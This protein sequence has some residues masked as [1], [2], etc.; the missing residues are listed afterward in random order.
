MEYGVVYCSPLWG[1]IR[2][3]WSSSWEGT[4]TVLLLPSYRYQYQHRRR[5]CTTLHAV[6]RTTTLWVGR[7]V[8]ISGVLLRCG[9][10]E[11]ND[12]MEEDGMATMCEC[13]HGCDASCGLV[14]N[15]SASSECGAKYRPGAP[16]DCVLLPN[17]DNNH[18]PA[19]TVSLVL[20]N[21]AVCLR[22]GHRCDHG[23]DR[24]GAQSRRTGLWLSCHHCNVVD[25]T[26]KR[27]PVPHGRLRPQRSAAVMYQCGG[28]AP[29]PTV[30]VSAEFRCLPVLDHL[31]MFNHCGKYGAGL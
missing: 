15:R 18:R 27:V 6:V 13:G 20:A 17:R 26:T 28:D 4:P 5:K 3:V 23:L 16:T 14:V 25:V 19:T 31:P 9:R 12:G 24:G 29:S 1:I 30:M 21:A 10:D 8:S 22:D 11:D 7:V 2:R